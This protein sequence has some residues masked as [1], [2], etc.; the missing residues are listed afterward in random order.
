MKYLNQLIEVIKE[1]EK[2]ILTVNNE[3]SGEFMDEFVSNVKSRISFKGNGN[4]RVSVEDLKSI[5]KDFIEQL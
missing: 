3:I 1:K 4:K 5:E 2:N